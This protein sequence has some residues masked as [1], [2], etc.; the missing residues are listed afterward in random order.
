VAWFV[1]AY[2]KE[3]QVNE[4][5]IRILFVVKENGTLPCVYWCVAHHV[6][7][8]GGATYVLTRFCFF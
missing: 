6:L 4:I 1:K 2:K 7:T 8:P 3:V 5:D